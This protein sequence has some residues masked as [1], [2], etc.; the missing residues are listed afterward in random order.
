[1]ICRVKTV[2]TLVTRRSSS[3]GSMP[4]MH[5]N[6]LWEGR[7]GGK[8]SGGGT[9]KQWLRNGGKV[10]LSPT[11]SLEVQK[12]DKIQKIILYQLKGCA[13]PPVARV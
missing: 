4:K 3:P 9:G 5:Q 1:M 7:D 2:Q 13:V 10:L 8:L 12:Y 6:A 11:I